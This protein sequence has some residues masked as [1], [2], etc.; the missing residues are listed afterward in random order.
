MFC[1]KCGTQSLY[2]TT[3]CRKCGAKLIS[4]VTEN[5]TPEKSE[6]PTVPKENT[7]IPQTPINL[8]HT[9]VQNLAAPIDNTDE[10]RRFMDNQIQ[11][12]TRYRTADDLLK[13]S[14][15]LVIL[16]LLFAVITVLFAIQ[17]FPVG[18]LVGLLLGYGAAYIA[19][20]I[21]YA[22]QY[23][24]HC[25][26]QLRNDIDL[27]DL[28]VFLNT[29]LG[30]LSPKFGEW[31]FVGQ[32]SAGETM[33]GFK[34]TKST[35]A[36]VTFRKNPDGNMHYAIS[37]RKGNVT[38]YVVISLQ[39]L[40]ASKTDAG[41]GRLACLYKTAPIISAALKYYNSSMAT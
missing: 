34:Y 30:N 22:I 7:S 31:G 27:N 1:Q 29:T 4:D 11:A 24:K 19:G 12:T 10:F 36:I 16:W 40:S 39:G 13:K 23:K 6:Q 25:T 20:R 3:C 14:K 41:F 28:V 37:A 5:L 8:T 35:H 38:Y 32:G 2:K 26:G 9:A 15:P 33:I 17:E 18:L 21:M